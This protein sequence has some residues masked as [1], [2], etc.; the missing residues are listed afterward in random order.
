M[1]PGF[2][3]KKRFPGDPIKRSNLD[4]ALFT[5]ELPLIKKPLSFFPGHQPM[6]PIMPD[7]PLQIKQASKSHNIESKKVMLSN[8]D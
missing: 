1:K 8:S 5:Y 4:Y 6:G 3:G 7:D 2:C